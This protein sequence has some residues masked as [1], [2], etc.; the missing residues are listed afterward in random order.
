MCLEVSFS[1]SKNYEVRLHHKQQNIRYFKTAYLSG[2]V[3]VHKTGSSKLR[4]LYSVPRRTPL[5]KRTK[6]VS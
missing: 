1:A 6:W 3:Y 5:A 4:D 2:S